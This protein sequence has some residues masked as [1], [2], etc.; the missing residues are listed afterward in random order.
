MGTR[1]KTSLFFPHGRQGL[2]FSNRGPDIVSLKSRGLIGI[3]FAHKWGEPHD[4]FHAEMKET[5]KGLEEESF[6]EWSA[7]YGQSSGENDQSERGKALW[8]SICTLRNPR[9]PSDFPLELP[10]LSGE[11][12]L[13]ASTQFLQS[14]S[15]LVQLS[16]MDSREVDFNK[17]LHGSKMVCET[18]DLIQLPLFVEKKKVRW[19]AKASEVLWAVYWDQRSPWLPIPLFSGQFWGWEYSASAH[20]PLKSEFWAPFP[21]CI[22]KPISGR[23]TSGFIFIWS[24]GFAAWHDFLQQQPYLLFKELT[25]WM[26]TS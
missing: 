15:T 3:N 4:G 12:G 7:K 6:M 17:E 14:T 18:P 21:A 10:E 22:L 20:L 1:V 13:D 8:F 19:F 11:C 24:F 23:L 9:I 26:L 25:K 16:P 5:V 2:M